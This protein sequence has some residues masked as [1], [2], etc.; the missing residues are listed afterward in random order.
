MT[1]SKPGRWLATV[2]QM[3]L[4][5]VAA[6]L[7]R[8]PGWLR[9]LVSC[10]E[11]LAHDPLDAIREHSFFHCRN[12]RSGFRK[13]GRSRLWRLRPGYHRWLGGWSVLCASNVE[14]G[15]GRWAGGME[16]TAH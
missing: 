2:P 11:A 3:R 6:Q 12:R 7:L 13:T 16:K 1:D 10:G 8:V 5:R 15:W 4:L 9:F 14:A